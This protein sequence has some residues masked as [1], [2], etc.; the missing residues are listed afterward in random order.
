MNAVKFNK[1]LISKDACSDG[2]AFSEGKSM[3]ETWDSLKRAGWMMWLYRQRNV[4]KKKCVM[5]AI[6][7]AELCIKNFEDKYPND[8]RPREAIESARKVLKNDTKKNRSAALSAAWS[9]W[10]AALSAAWSAE[11][12]AQQQICDYIRK[13]IKIK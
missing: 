10:S 8:K 13:I 3:Q 9:A 4:N 6:Y 12:A 7:S 5:V 2:L 1:W 11:S